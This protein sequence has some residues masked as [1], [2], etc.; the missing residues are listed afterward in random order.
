MTLLLQK[1]DIFSMILTV[2]CDYFPEQH[3]L[4][5]RQCVFCEVRSEFLTRSKNLRVCFFVCFVL[6]VCLLSPYVVVLVKNEV[7]VYV[8]HTYKQFRFVTMLATKR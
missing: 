4:V 2:K 7:C 3:S 1:S 5:E 8:G 6:M